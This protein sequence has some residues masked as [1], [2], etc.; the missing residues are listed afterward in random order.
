[1]QKLK[2]Q[3]MVNFEQ[4]EIQ[5]EEKRTADCAGHEHYQRLIENI[6]TVIS[7][8]QKMEEEG[9]GYG[10]GWKYGLI[11]GLSIANQIINKYYELHG[12]ID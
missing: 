7:N 3:K 6:N 10:E 11:D 9:M 2:E 5:H 4:G 1:V 12:S 8:A